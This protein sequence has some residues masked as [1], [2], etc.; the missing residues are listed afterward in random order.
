MFS[1]I[2]ILRNIN[3]KFIFKNTYNYNLLQ[4]EIIL[5]NDCLKVRSI[6]K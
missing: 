6:K 1:R 3:S 2:R 4:N 5:T